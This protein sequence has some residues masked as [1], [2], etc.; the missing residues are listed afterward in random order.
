MIEP[1]PWWIGFFWT[2]TTAGLAFL[3]GEAA[4][5]CAMRPRLAVCLAVLLALGLAVIRTLLHG[6]W[7]VP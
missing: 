6:L 5:I 2:A 4:G 7:Y 3:V 1:E